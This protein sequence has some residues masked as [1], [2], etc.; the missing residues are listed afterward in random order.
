MHLNYWRVIKV[1]N[2]NSL[3]LAIVIG[4]GVALMT[5]FVLILIVGGTITV[6]QYGDFTWLLK[7]WVLTTTFIGLWIF[8]TRHF[9]KEFMV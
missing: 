5:L 3:I 1:N 8:F 9:Y 2:I 6:Y 7:H 4:A